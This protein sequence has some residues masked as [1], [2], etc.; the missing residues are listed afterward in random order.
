MIPGY[1]CRG[2][3]VLPDGAGVQPHRAAIAGGAQA[4]R[5]NCAVVQDAAAAASVLV[6]G[7]L[8]PS[9]RTGSPVVTAPTVA[10]LVPFS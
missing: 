8:D 2:I 9:T 4:V 1:S 10:A 3:A 6:T 7:Y 5:G